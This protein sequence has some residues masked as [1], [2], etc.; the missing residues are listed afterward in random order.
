M[1]SS[2]VRLEVKSLFAS[3]IPGE[4][5]VD[6]SAQYSSIPEVLS[7]KGITL[8]NNW[9]GI[10]FIGDREETVS[11]AADNTRGCY[12][13]RGMVQ[14]FVMAPAQANVSDLMVARADAIRNVFRGRNLNGVMIEEVTPPN[15]EQGAILELESNYMCA[16]FDIIYYLDINL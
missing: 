8:A 14:V 1:S 15:T 5:L 12:R 7:K 10:L 13:E 6:L 4:N 3:N 9:C 11:L 2:K 16:A